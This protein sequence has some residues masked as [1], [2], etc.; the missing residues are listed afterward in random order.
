MVFGDDRGGGNEKCIGSTLYQHRK[1]IVQNQVHRKHFMVQQ[2]SHRSDFM[3][4]VC[5][6]GK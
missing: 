5:D 6:R 2:R 4:I 3:I 1:F